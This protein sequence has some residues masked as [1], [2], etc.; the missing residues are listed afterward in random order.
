MNESG[1]YP[2]SLDGDECSS[3][4]LSGGASLA[5]DTEGPEDT[6]EGEGVGSGGAG[7]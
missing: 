1:S 3:P 2:F 4:P 7:V 6:E 5:E